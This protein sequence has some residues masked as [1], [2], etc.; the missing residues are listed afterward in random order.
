MIK[1]N[2]PELKPD[3]P[4]GHLDCVACITERV[5]ISNT[6]TWMYKNNL[7]NYTVNWG[8]AT[9]LRIKGTLY[10]DTHTKCIP[11]RD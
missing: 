10:Q 1:N 4:S 6:C 3:T 11:V 7:P 5:I 2:L 9:F 8:L